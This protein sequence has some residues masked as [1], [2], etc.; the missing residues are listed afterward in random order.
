MRRLVERPRS[1]FNAAVAEV[2]DNDVLQRATVGFAVVSTTRVHARQMI[3]RIAGFI[4]GM[5]LAIPV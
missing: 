2:D 3:G 5:G 4:E 1:R